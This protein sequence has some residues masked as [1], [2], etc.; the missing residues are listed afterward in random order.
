[1]TRRRPRGI[2]DRRSF[3]TTRLVVLGLMSWGGWPAVPEVKLRGRVVNP[4][5]AFVLTRLE[6]EGIEPAPEA[7]RVTVIRRL[8]FD[9]TGLPPTPAEVD[10]PGL[11]LARIDLPDDPA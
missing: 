1:M 8:S 3:A 11:W 6:A 9:L 7:D 2:A 10:A 4:I 5:D